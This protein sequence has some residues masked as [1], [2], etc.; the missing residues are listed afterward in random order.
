MKC[1]APR[2]KV[3]PRWY[4]L[5]RALPFRRV[6]LRGDRQGQPTR[7]FLRGDRHEGQPHGFLR[8]L[9]LAL[10]D[11]ALRDPLSRLAL[12]LQDLALRDSLRDE[13]LARKDPLRD[14]ALARQEL[15]LRNLALALWDLALRASW[16][17]RLRLGLSLSLSRNVDWRTPSADHLIVTCVVPRC[18][19][20]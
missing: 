1:L 16:L 5:I 19:S 12:A 6:F 2:T 10:R 8:A 15:A 13:A 9:A 17:S 18:D 3:L 7:V 20:V 14:E 4:L 11:L